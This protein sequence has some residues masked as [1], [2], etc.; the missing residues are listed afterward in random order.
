MQGAIPL[1]DWRFYVKFLAYLL[2]LVLLWVGYLASPYKLVYNH[3]PSEPL[4]WYLVSEVG[5]KEQLE[6][7]QLVVFKYECP[8]DGNG[9]CMFGGAVPFSDGY[10]LLKR[11]QGQHGHTVRTVDYGG[12]HRNVVTGQGYEK[13]TG[14]IR[15]TTSEGKPLNTVFSPGTALTIPKGKLYMGNQNIDNAFDSRYFGLVDRNRIIG[16]AEKL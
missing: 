5:P 1:P 10:Q 15:K 4:G 13:D 11:V 12:A 9:E 7:G 3:T 2:A 16:V 6:L 14:A 8:K